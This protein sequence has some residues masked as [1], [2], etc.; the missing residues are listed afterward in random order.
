M[1]EEM[2]KKEKEWYA[3]VEEVRKIGLA[4]L[5]KGSELYRFMKKQCREMRKQQSKENNDKK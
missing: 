3:K 4:N 2:T 1:T 5:E